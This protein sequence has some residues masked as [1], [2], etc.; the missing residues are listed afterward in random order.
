ME[1]YKE[2]GIRDPC[3]PACEVPIPWGESDS[4]PLSTACV[5][6]PRLLRAEHHLPRCTRDTSDRR[7]RFLPCLCSDSPSANI[8][9]C[10]KGTAGPLSLHCQFSSFS[11][12]SLY[13][14]TPGCGGQ[15]PIQQTGTLNTG[16]QLP[17][18]E[19]PTTPEKLQVCGTFLRTCIIFLL[20]HKTSHFPSFQKEFFQYI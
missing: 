7:M 3:S 8:S 1:Q 10:Q 16:H 18:Y 19:L 9:E 11:K 20:I 17:I 5:S 13:F 12:C 6:V 4:V 14:Q 15:I 2:R